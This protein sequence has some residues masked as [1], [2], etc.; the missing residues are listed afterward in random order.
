MEE[1]G[2]NGVTHGSADSRETRDVSHAIL[3]E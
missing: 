3:N 2:L 1:G